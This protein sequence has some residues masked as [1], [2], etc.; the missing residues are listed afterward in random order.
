MSQS[1]PFNSS[2]VS[3]IV[4]KL[5]SIAISS[6]ARMYLPKEKLFVFRLR[7]E[8][9]KEVLEGLSNRYTATALIGL[10]GED[11]D[12]ISEVLG[13]DTC[14]DVCGHLLDN[15]QNFK[16]LGEIAL[17]AWAAKA[18]EH[19][20]A[21]KAVDLL[22]RM[23]LA[24]TKGAGNPTVEVAWALT[25]FSVGKVESDMPYAEKLADMLMDSF[26]RK[27]DLFPHAPSTEG[28]SP[29]RRHVSCFAD[30]VYPVQA[31][32]IYHQATGNERAAAIAKSCASRMC[33][34]Q[35][36][37][38]QWWWHFDIRSGRFIEGYPVYSVHQDSM[39]PMAFRA[40]RDACGVDHSE[41]I[42]K[43][44]KWLA[45]SKEINGSLIDD[46]RQ[47]IWRK[48]FRREPSKL[49][50]KMQAA[51]SSMHPAVRVPGTDILF[52]PVAIDYE[53]R[54]YHMGWILYAWPASKGV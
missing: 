26:S 44:L 42:E 27:A 29:L 19:P 3:D 21:N 24:D 11:D 28:M 45:H 23:N 39:A 49:V 5:R 16:E 37:E 17:T 1:C 43:G 40:L 54:P 52:P 53:S 51:A 20:D 41:M 2:F 22:K 18:I 4:K 35:G 31:L 46:D 13:K 12:V 15:A 33:K 48:V 34:L 30:F 7:K 9:E 38:G 25:A 8:G 6:L 10:S 36:P 32:S 47:I 14:M 50:R